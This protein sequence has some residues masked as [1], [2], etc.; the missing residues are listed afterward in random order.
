MK[1]A[2]VV[3][4][5]GIKNRDKEVTLSKG[6]MHIPFNRKEEGKDGSR[7][8]GFVQKVLESQLPREE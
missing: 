6:R 3:E 5:I 4:R 1:I 2:G 7:Y 8:V